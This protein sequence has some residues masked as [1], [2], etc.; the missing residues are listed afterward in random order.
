MDEK[1]EQ[2]TIVNVEGSSS[3]TSPPS[4]EWLYPFLE[5]V[6][7]SGRLGSGPNESVGNKNAIHTV[8]VSIPWGMLIVEFIWSLSVVGTGYALG[9]REGEPLYKTLDEEFWKSRLNVP[10]SVTYGVGWALFVLLAFFIRE[11]TNRYRSACG[12][13]HLLETKI[14]YFLRDI[15]YNYPEGT[16]HPGDI[17]R[18][19]RHLVAYPIALKMAIRNE[20]EQEQLSP[21]LHPADVDDV[22]QSDCMPSQC[23]RVLRAY[24]YAGDER[25]P[26]GF[27]YADTK[28]TPSG[29]GVR[30]GLVK[31]VDAIDFAA[32]KAMSIA[33]FRPSIAYVNHLQIFLYIWMMFLPL[34]LIKTSGW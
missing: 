5:S 23:T 7:T 33:E 14:K 24:L 12:A 15:I 9:S 31:Y 1:S 34:S 28:K 29:I 11:A 30:F 6:R 8:L 19:A 2:L 25:L 3:S 22:L 26:Y 4:F 27:Q 32:Q 21:I 16:W 10:S 20:C 13:I 18:I 17:D